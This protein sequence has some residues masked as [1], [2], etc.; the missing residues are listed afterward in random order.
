[1]L[2]QEKGNLKMVGNGCSIPYP[3]PNPSLYKAEAF[4]ISACISTM[5]HSYLV[6]ERAE[7]T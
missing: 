4:K 2:N 1:M 6:S 5:G 3:C 7:Q